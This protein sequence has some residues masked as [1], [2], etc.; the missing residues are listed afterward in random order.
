MSLVALLLAGFAPAANA[1]ADQLKFGVDMARRG[2]WNE[3]LF[4]F[5]QA[6][7]ANPGDV[8]VLNNLAVAY[9]AVGLFEQALDTY[10]RALK[11][12]PS[13]RELRR[14]YARFIEFYQAFKPDAES[15]DASEGDRP[16][17]A[18]PESPTGDAAGT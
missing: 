8:R 1:A 17:D 4:R 16:P 2:L 14:N 13:N 12:S 18:A 15:L 9:E 7:R 11:A 10:R 5:R 3:A 6:E